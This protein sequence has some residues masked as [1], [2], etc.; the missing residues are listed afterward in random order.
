M[1][2]VELE[3]AGDNEQPAC[4]SNIG[5]SKWRDPLDDRYKPSPFESLAGAAVV[6][7]ATRSSMTFGRPV[8]DNG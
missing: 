7:K 1:A 5:V 3:D 2:S 4:G 6:C 8:T